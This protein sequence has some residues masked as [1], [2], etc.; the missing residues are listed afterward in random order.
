MTKRKTKII[1][2]GG[3]YGKICVYFFR[4]LHNNCDIIVKY[5]KHGKFASGFMVLAWMS[6]RCMTKARVFY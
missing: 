4:Q 3:S 2:P 6:F 1:Y 5:E